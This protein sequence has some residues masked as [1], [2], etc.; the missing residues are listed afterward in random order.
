MG[1]PARQFHLQPHDLGGMSDDFDSEKL[2]AHRMRLGPRGEAYL[3]G[4]RFGRA[5][6][7]RQARL[8]IV[9][10][11]SASRPE[12]VST[13]VSV[14]AKRSD[15]NPKAVAGIARSRCIIG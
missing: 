13:Q 12:S 4:S 7:V 9:G 5:G 15:V 2:V 10:Y 6:L 8:L 1:G 11:R 3:D 14:T